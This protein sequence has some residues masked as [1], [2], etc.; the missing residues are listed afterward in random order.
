MLTGNLRLTSLV[1]LMLYDILTE[2][3]ED[4]G[5]D[6]ASSRDRAWIVS[7]INH[8]AREIYNTADLTGSEREQIFV[9]DV[10]EQQIAL[11]WYVGDIIGLRDYDSLDPIQQV[12]MRPRYLRDSWTRQSQLTP[13]RQWRRKGESALKRNILDEGTLTITL[14]AVATTAFDVFIVGSSS[15]AARI[16]ER[17]RFAAGEATK[18]TV[19]FFSNVTSIVKSA[20]T[21]YDLVVTTLDGTEV[22]D[23]PSHLTKAKFVLVQVLDKNDNLT[24]SQLIELC[25]KHV[26]EPMVNDTD[27]FTAG[28]LYDKAIYWKTLEFIAAKQEGKEDRVLMAAAKSQ[29]LL[30]NI[31]ANS[32]SKI[33]MKFAF[34][35]NPVIASFQAA[36]NAARNGI[37]P[38]NT[39]QW[40]Q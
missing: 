13:M 40:E 14:P 3:T 28:E 16:T 32:A 19:N 27:V 10:D 5:S 7:Q 4:I 33:E 38:T 18:S 2:V 20:A 21:T 15:L 23:I 12:D 8:A 6:S 36:S 22:S 31:L 26:F 9:L 11:P 37:R 17:V 1:N 24:E 29:A 35:E 34:G 30:S 39:N 25:Y